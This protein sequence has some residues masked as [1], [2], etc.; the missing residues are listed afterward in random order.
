MIANR[1]QLLCS[2]SGLAF[3]CLSTREVAGVGAFYNVVTNSIPM[4]AAKTLIRL[5]LGYP[6]V[7]LRTPATRRPKMRWMFEHA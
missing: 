1:L 3:F 4:D 2:F 7:G 6:R 5:S